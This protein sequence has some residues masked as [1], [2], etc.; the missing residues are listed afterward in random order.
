MHYAPH[1][2]W[3]FDFT[4]EMRRVVPRASK[5][6]LL[7]MADALAQLSS[8]G[9]LRVAPEVLAAVLAR[10]RT[11]LGVE[12]TAAAGAAVAAAASSSSSSSSSFSGADCASLTQALVHLHVAP[13]A[14]LLSG[15]YTTFVALLPPPAAAAGGSAAAATAGAGA[16]V[17]TMLWALGAFWRSN[18]ECLWLRQHP[19]IVA[20]LVTAAQVHL[21]GYEPLQLK[22]SLVAL[23]AMGY[24]PGFEF[25]RAHEAAVLGRVGEI[26]PK[27]LE[28]ILRGYQELAF[29]GPGQVV[30]REELAKKQAEAQQQ[31]QQQQ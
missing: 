31:Q 26:W 20:A 6:Q 13:G 3:W 16:Q 19:E 1:P 4:L 30:L 11:L 5:Q 2:E 27:T 25:L 10:A 7:M 12:S 15:L 17:A 18:A 23:A 24:N 8:R 9:E 21:P 28:H 29:S 14:S 22:R